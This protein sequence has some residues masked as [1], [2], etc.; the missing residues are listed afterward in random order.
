MNKAF[1]VNDSSEEHG[2]IVFAETRN[3]AKANA[4][5]DC[6]YIERSVRREKKYDKYAETGVP[7]EVLLTD[8]WWFTCNKCS[9]YYVTEEN[10]GIVIN[11]KVYCARCAQ[12]KEATNANS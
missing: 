2:E 4:D 6:D 5:L 10:G 8:G 12:A 1:Y 7:T 3:Q 9:N 11:G